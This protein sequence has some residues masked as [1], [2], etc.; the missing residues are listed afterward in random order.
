MPWP[1]STWE[2]GEERERERERERVRE[3]DPSVSLSP[4]EHCRLGSRHRKAILPAASA[5]VQ[6]PQEH[7]TRG[8]GQAPCL[9][10]QRIPP[11]R[12]GGE[13]GG[14]RERGRK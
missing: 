8:R 14:G 12:G 11:G 7:K 13:V 1:K 5:A 4:H 3:R 9:L 2:G 6:P 10:P